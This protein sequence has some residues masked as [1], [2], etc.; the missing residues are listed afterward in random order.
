MKTP[1][2]GCLVNPTECITNLLPLSSQAENGS[3]MKY[4]KGLSIANNF[5]NWSILVTW[6]VKIIMVYEK[7]YEIYYLF[8]QTFASSG[9][10]SALILSLAT[11]IHVFVNGL[12]KKSTSNYTK[13]L[14][15]KP[16]YIGFDNLKKNP[17]SPR[18]KDSNHQDTIH[19]MVTAI[20]NLKN[21][22]QKHSTTLGFYWNIHF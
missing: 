10:H 12:S 19:S 14:P 9:Y 2:N 6:Y 17:F 15:P 13:D 16:N 11:F 1:F 18:E 20:S 8:S 4:C 7:R 21:P 5:N 22:K 3:S